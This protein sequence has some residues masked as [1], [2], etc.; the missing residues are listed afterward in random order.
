MAKLNI[1]Q[2]PKSREYLECLHA[3]SGY[4]LVQLDFS[5][6]EPVILTAASKDPALYN[7]YGPNAKPNCIYL[8]TAANIPGLGDNIIA[9][10]Y[11]PKNPTT[12]S[13]AHAKKVCKKDR[14]VAKTVHLAAS[15]NA[16]P[17]K[18]HETL[19]LSGIDITIEE[20]AEIHRAYWKLYAGVKDFSY[21]L[22]RQWRNNNGYILNGFGRP[23]CVPEELTKD[24]VNRFCQST[25][26]D[27]LMAYVARIQYLR[28]TRQVEMYPWIVDF[29]D[30]T[31][32]EV[33]QNSIADAVSILKDALTWLNKFRASEIPISGSVEVVD[34]L[35]QLK[36]EE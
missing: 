23:L 17:N 30:E 26:H 5:S 12:E 28:S 13:V 11:D 34:N 29:H 1:Q 8:Y 10:G 33:P 35:A 24:L 4:R 18:I 2:Q 32:W 9:S 31:I 20:V 7:I 36:V 14:N 25:G 3:R 21:Q 16:G 22:M 19:Q 27:A 6:V 15:Y